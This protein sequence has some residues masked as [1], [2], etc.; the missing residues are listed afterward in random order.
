MLNNTGVTILEILLVM[1]IITIL[2]G[3]A[4]SFY[5]GSENLIELEEEQNRIVSAL[6][7]AKGN[8][9]AIEQGYAWGVH[10]DNTDTSR[11][12]FTVFS[13]V[14]YAG[15]GTTSTRY[16]SSEVEYEAPAGGASSDVIFTKRTGTTTAAA[17]IT[18][19][20]RITPDLKKNINVSTQGVI[21]R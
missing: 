16:L 15:S 2:G 8:A 3:A 6:R 4:F 11:P 12:F 5:Y 1:G 14:S 17:T 21:T 7:E 10:F 9:V 13:G 18:V 19:R 20:L